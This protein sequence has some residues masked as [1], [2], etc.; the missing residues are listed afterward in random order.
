SHDK[1]AIG[2]PR[3]GGYSTLDLTS[4]AYVQGRHLYPER[5]RRGL[6]GTPLADA[7]RYRGIAEHPCA[8]H[9]R[10]DLFQQ[11]QPFRAK[12]IVELNKTGGIAA[13]LSK[14]PD[15][16]STDWIGYVRKH[17]RNGAG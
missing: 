14:A 8:C 13:R 5:R 15:E 7:R 4:I 1:T 3:E 10:R 17:N 12:P 16:A 2:S 6:D 11:F 9:S